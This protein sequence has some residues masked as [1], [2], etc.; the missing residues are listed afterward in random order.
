MAQV[1]KV[2]SDLQPVMNYD[3]SSYTVGALNDVTSAVTVQPQG[4]KLDFGT[5]TSTV[6]H[7]TG[8]EVNTIIQTLQQLATVYIYEFTTGGTYD[9]LA[10]AVY[11]TGAWD[12]S[13]GGSVDVAVTAAV[14]ACTTAA[15]ATFTN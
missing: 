6:G 4:P 7:Y 10:V 2:H 14:G 12:F 13:N 1:T 15:S 9:S 3:A 8:D 5:I 11:P